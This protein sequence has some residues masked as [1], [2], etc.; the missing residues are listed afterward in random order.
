MIKTI[1]QLFDIISSMH[2]SWKIKL[3]TRAK[4]ERMNIKHKIKQEN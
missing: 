4:E 1:G 2:K 3:E